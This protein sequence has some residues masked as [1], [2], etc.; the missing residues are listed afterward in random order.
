MKKKCTICGESKNLDEFLKDKSKKDGTRNQCKVCHNLRKRKTPIKPTPREGYKYCASCNKEKELGEFNMRTYKGTK[1]P[2]SYCKP[3]ERLKDS[4]RYH[5]TCKSCGLSYK[6]G[7]KDNKL[8]VECHRD[9]MRQDKV[10]Y[11]FKERDFKGE[12]NPMFGKQRFGKENPNYKPDKTDK[13]R[14]QHR[15]VEGYGLWRKAVYERDDYTCQCCKDS[16]GGNLTS[17]HLD[18]WDWCR[19]RRLDIDNGITLCKTCHLDFHSKYGYGN[20]TKQQFITYM[21]ERSASV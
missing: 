2:F 19:E 6:S 16:K 9:L 21:N 11:K 1:S 5:H 4:N 7:R 18:S 15:L 17:H 3:C 12:K 8:C 14:Y 10:M 20:N 13:E